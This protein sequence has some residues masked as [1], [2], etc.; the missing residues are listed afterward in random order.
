MNA[1][2]ILRSS[3]LRHAQEMG[4]WIRRLIAEGGAA[5]V[6]LLMLLENV[7]P[8]IPSELVMPLAGFLASQ[9]TMSIFAVIAA[10]SLGSLAGTCGWYWLGRHWGHE[11]VA[12]FVERHGHW[13]TISPAELERSRRWLSSKGRWSLLVA[14]LVPGVRT[15]ISLPAGAAE[16]PLGTFLAFSAVGTVLWTA[17]LAFAGMKL[18]ERHAELGQYLGHIS[19]AVIVGLVTIYVVRLVSRRRSRRG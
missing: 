8:P 14:R 17:L 16:V 2:F 10:G 4:E 13:L 3:V 15:L 19:T 6:A 9:G 1:A 5:G 18:G 12:R 7:V 11:K